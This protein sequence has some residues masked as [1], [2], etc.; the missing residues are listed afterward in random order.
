M[1]TEKPRIAEPKEAIPEPKKKRGMYASDRGGQGIWRQE[2]LTGGLCESGEKESA[3]HQD[4]IRG[5][6][7]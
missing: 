6:Q 5:G 2:H 3:R 1:P 7:G 4:E